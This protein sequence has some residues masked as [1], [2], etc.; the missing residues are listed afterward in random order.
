VILAAVLAVVAVVVAARP[1]LRE[2]Q[3]K[4]DRIGEPTAEER[5]RLRLAE[6][7]D[8][9]LAALKDLEFEHRTGKI[10]DEDYREQVGPLRRRAAATL[11]AL[12][13]PK[14]SEEQEEDRIRADGGGTS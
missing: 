13:P 6:E 10:S 7:R 1:F 2:P 5:E 12:A 11:R 3:A 14:P 4:D 9:V 8:R